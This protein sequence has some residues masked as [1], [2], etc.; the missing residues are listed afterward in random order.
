MPHRSSTL[1]YGEG[2]GT[3]FQRISEDGWQG[4]SHGVVQRCHIGVQSMALLN[5]AATVSYT[6]SN[7]GST[8]LTA[9]AQ[10]G[11][12]PLIDTTPGIY[13]LTEA[14]SMA[15]SFFAE[16]GV[17][18]PEAESVFVVCED[19]TQTKERSR[20]YYLVLSP[21]FYGVPLLEY[22]VLRPMSVSVTTDMSAV[23][24]DEGIVELHAGNI[25]IIGDAVG[26]AA[27]LS[28][29]AISL[30]DLSAGAQGVVESIFY[31]DALFLQVFEGLSRIAADGS[32]YTQRVES[33]TPLWQLRYEA[34]AEGGD[35]LLRPVWV[36]TAEEF[37]QYEM[38]IP[39]YVL[40]DAQT[41]R[42]IER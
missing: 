9:E 5:Y 1:F 18:I 29:D 41:G 21:A 39:N 8:R 28:P 31:P 35:T 16:A 36:L 30:E 4:S 37:L 7:L 20:Y 27:I 13:T 24:S 10:R 6:K 11:D 25:P 15:L 34:Y 22:P 26:K 42:E 12:A 17:Q 23:V 19:P 40:F 3:Q 2:A 32:T 33:I 38:H 14:E